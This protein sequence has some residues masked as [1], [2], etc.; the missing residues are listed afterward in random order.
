MKA[1]QLLEPQVFEICEIPDPVLTEG[2]VLLEVAAAGI[3]HSDVRIVNRTVPT[4]P[5]PLT[6]GHETAAK[7]IDPNGA[8]GFVEGEYVLVAGIWGCG[9]CRP[10]RLGRPNACETWARSLPIPI[11][12]GLGFPGGMAEYM[13]APHQALVSLGD[14]DPVAAAPLADAAVTPAHAVSLAR[15]LLTPD[16][17]V[18]VI[19]I[20]GL[21][22]MAL[23]ILRATTATRI[24]AVDADLDRVQTAAQ[25]GADVALA[26]GEDTAARILE[27]TDGLGAHVVIDIVGV[28]ATLKTAVEA[29]R[30][31]GA[32]LMVGLGGGSLPM[33]AGGTNR[34]DGPPWGVRV[35]R[36]YG[37][38][39]A[40]VLDVIAL[41]RAGRIRAEVETH[42]LLDA[43]SVLRRLEQGLVPGRAVL[44]P[45]D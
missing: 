24:V 10:C 45:P 4:L 25:Y 14:L 22:H 41:A 26:S 32:I 7:V 27:L 31:Y 13:V 29:V 6:L 35:V 17:T 16:A 12:P 9:T 1:A 2:Q 37:A 40:D 15:D 42:D 33:T 23:Q 36:P 21:G 39:V 44:I 30:T 28:D 18:V 11:G 20:G 8:P 43:P 3:C 5:L 34:H 19:G 38:T